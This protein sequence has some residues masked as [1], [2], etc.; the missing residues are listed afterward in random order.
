MSDASSK[1]S[2]LHYTEFFVAEDRIKNKQTWIPE[3]QLQDFTFNPGFHQYL[4]RKEL[5]SFEWA[6]KVQ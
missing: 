1:G 3:K 6:I 2:Q 5:Y 4:G